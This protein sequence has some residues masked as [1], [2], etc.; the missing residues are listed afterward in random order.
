MI[1]SVVGGANVAVVARMERALVARLHIEQP[2]QL[3]LR[4]GVGMR[5]ERATLPSHALQWSLQ[6]GLQVSEG[7]QHG[8]LRIHLGALFGPVTL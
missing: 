1:A 5:R 2:A 8:P 7:G 4:V 6:R 3:L